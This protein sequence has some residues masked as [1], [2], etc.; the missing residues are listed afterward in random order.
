MS[1]ELYGQKVR[2]MREQRGWTQEELASRAGV[3]K[4]TLQDVEAAVGTKGPQRRT[5]ERI[6][7]ALG[8]GQA[9]E[10]EVTEALITAA[11]GWPRD[12]RTMALI[13]GQWLA[14]LPEADRDQEFSAVLLRVTRA[15]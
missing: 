4:R 7:A 12:V 1:G 5:R 14:A 15:R 8:I 2:K 3:P 13:I 10:A 9:A 11:E 6:D